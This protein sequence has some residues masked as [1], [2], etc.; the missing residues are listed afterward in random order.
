MTEHHFTDRR[1]GRREATCEEEGYTGDQYCSFCL[2]TMKTGEVIP[3]AGHQFGEAAGA[4]EATCTARGYSGD[5]TCQACGLFVPGEVLPFADHTMENGVCTACGWRTPG[6]YADGQLQAAWDEFVSQ[7]HAAVRD[8]VLTDVSGDLKGMALVAGEE[9]TGF[10]A[11]AGIGRAGLAELWLPRSITT[12]SFPDLAE[13][14]KAPEAPERVVIYCQV[15][16]VPVNCF[17]GA[18]VVVG[19]ESRTYPVTVRYVG[20]NQRG[21]AAA[22]LAGEKLTEGG[23]DSEPPVTLSAVYGENEEKP[24]SYSEI[25][26]GARAYVLSRD[27]GIPAEIYVT[28]GEPGRESRC[29]IWRKPDT[30]EG[31]LDAS[32]RKVTA[33]ESDGAFAGRTYRIGRAEMERDENGKNRAIRKE[34]E[35]TVHDV[36]AGD[37]RM[38]VTV[39]GPPAAWPEAAGYGNNLWLYAESGGQTAMAVC[40]SG[41]FRGDCVFTFDTPDGLPDALYLCNDLPGKERIRIWKRKDAFADG[42]GGPG[43]A[44]NGSWALAQNIAEQY[45]VPLEYGIPQYTPP[46]A[47]PLTAYMVPGADCEIGI[48]GENIFRVDHRGPGAV[49]GRMAEW[50]SMIEEQSGGAIRFAAD[51]DY[52]DVLVC[53]NLEYLYE[54]TYRGGGTTSK[55]YA[56]RLTLTAVR[57]TDPSELRTMTLTSKPG[58]QATVRSGSD[59]FWMLPPDVAGTPEF[60]NFIQAILGWYAPEAE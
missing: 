58:N 2:Q 47:T 19:D 1:E 59:K 25:R 50:I 36:L 45:G 51:P 43:Q 17:H 30:Y 4:A 57:L 7:G 60:E 16:V 35:V 38:S 24:A 11:G 12:L 26:D 37:G 40:R 33:E 53:A 31:F 14:W 20:I 42:P 10:E 34:Y 39:S 21:K 48:D 41:G 3:A 29:L 27:N 23:E 46:H 13:A 8:G 54:G 22:V 32:M 55:G 49:A 15:P 44:E 6:L 18:D 56:C 5:L 9:I 28:G 52:A